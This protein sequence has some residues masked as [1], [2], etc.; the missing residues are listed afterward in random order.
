MGVE[1]EKMQQKLPVIASAFS[2]FI[3]TTGEPIIITSSY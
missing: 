2:F 3:T 1:A